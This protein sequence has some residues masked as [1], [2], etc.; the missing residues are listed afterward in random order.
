MIDFHSHILP[1]IDDG[2]R[3][4]K[5]T[6][7]MIKEAYNAGFTAVISTS[8]YIDG[9]YDCDKQ[10]RE[11]LISDITSELEK[12]N[13]NIKIYN[14]AEAYVSRDLNLL[15]KENKLPTIN[16]GRYLLFELPMNSKVLFLEDTIYN[17]LSIN[18]IPV[19]AHPERYT[20]VQEDPNMLLE[21]IEK[22]VLFQMNYGS[23]SGFYGKEVKK[24]AIKLL[25]ANM[26]H[27][28]GT[29]A[30]RHNSLYTK[31]GE[32][33][34][35]II[36]IIG[37]DKFKELSEINPGHVINNEEIEIEKPTKIKKFFF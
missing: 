12:N 18:V 36:K 5:E 32:L 7:D 2:S 6:Y 10:T 33:K 25:K 22:G 35:N 4:I 27:F 20:F 28:L 16:N 26:I 11:K 8:H 14:G 24:T 3:N 30:H 1:E 15:V 21:L 17:L 13:I 23:P 9:S 31:M 19:I 34:N 29:D 37:E